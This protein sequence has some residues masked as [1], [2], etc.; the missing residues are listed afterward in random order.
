MK[1]AKQQLRIQNFDFLLILLCGSLTVIG[2]LAIYSAD[3]NLAMRHL[4]GFL[5]G[6]GRRS[7]L[8]SW[9]IISS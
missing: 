4:Y 2:T 7:S 6:L 3:E 8:L 1:N 5:L 9:I